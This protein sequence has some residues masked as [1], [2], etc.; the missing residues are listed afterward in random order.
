M[1][2]R[3]EHQVWSS[4]LTS[5]HCLVSL[6]DKHQNLMKLSCPRSIVQMVTLWQV[7]W[8]KPTSSESWHLGQS[9]R[10]MLSVSVG[11]LTSYSGWYK[12]DF[13][14][15]LDTIYQT[16]TSPAPPTMPQRYFHHNLV[17]NFLRQ[18]SQF[19]NWPIIRLLTLVLRDSWQVHL[20]LKE[21]MGDSIHHLQ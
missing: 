19:C 12:V 3:P 9:F 17:T 2:L 18:L 21:S 1:S 5:K 11:N 6:G 4:F 15:W 20:V 8:G 16:C 7:D 13:S 14:W 10:Q